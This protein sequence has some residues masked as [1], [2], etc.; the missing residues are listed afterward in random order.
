L[1]QD[2]KYIKSKDTIRVAQQKQQLL[3]TFEG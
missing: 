2:L 3:I 1:T